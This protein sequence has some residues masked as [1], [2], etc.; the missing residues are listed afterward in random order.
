[1][2]RFRYSPETVLAGVAPFLA[3]IASTPAASAPQLQP[4]R[5][6]LAMFLLILLVLGGFMAVVITIVLVKR[7]RTRQEATNAA[8]KPP[9]PMLDPWTEAARRVQPFDSKDQSR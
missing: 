1:M 2:N 3:T 9:A 7:V 4:V 6:A 5:S 8:R